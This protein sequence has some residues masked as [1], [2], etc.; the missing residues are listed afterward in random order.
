MKPVSQEV[1]APERIWLRSDGAFW[2]AV[3]HA[4]QEGNPEYVLAS[5]VATEIAKAEQAVW[6]RAIE[7]AGKHRYWGGFLNNQIITELESARTNEVSK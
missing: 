6:E 3:T 1:E 2:H 5:L 7:I 4:R